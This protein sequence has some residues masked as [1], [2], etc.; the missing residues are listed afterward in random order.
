M[1]EEEEEEEEVDD[2]E[3]KLRFTCVAMACTACVIAFT[4]VSSTSK[5]KRRGKHYFII[6]FHSKLK[7]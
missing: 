1:E 3:V 7:K 2:E 5:K 6:S 4:H